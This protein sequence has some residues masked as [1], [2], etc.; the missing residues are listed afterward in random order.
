MNLNNNRITRM[1]MIMMMIRIIKKKLR[2]I[3]KVNIRITKTMKT[4]R[5]A[6]MIMSM[7]KAITI[8]Q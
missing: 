1:R 3:M 4:M 6:R 8:S 7:I 5:M 2:I